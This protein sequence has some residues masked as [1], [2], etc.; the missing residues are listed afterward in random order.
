MAFI[1]QLVCLTTLSVFNGGKNL[2]KNYWISGRERSL[3]INAILFAMRQKI[4]SYYLFSSIISQV[5]LLKQ[6]SELLYSPEHL[7]IF[8]ATGKPLANH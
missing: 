4:A 2:W 8:R 7:R 1:L 6:C 5:Y 3:S